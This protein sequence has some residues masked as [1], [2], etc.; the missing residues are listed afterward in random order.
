M[1]EIKFNVHTNMLE[2]DRYT[3]SLQDVAEPEL[4]RDIFPYTE[5]PRITFNHRHVPMNMPEHL[6]ITDTTFRDGQ[7][8]RTPYTAKQIVDIYKLLHKLSGKKGIIRQSEFF[9]YSKKDREA[10]EKCMELG[11]KFP[12]ITT[13]IRASKKD[14]ELVKNLGIKETG[15]LMSCSDYHIF[16]KMGL[17]RGKAMEKYLGIAKDCMTSGL[18]PRCHLEDVTRADIY[19][20]VIPFVIEL[21]KL[22]EES[23]IPVKI[24]VCDTLGLGLAFPGISLPRSIPGIIYGL[25][26]YAGIPSERIEWHGHNDFYKSVA[27]ASTA[28]LY[29]ASNVNC[30]LLGIG[31]RTG[32]VPLEAMVFEYAAFKGTFDG[33]NPRIITEIADYISKETNYTIPPMT[34]FIGENF[35]T[36]KAG[37]HADGLIKDEEIY[38]I[39]DTKLMLNKPPLVTVSNTSGAAGIAYWLNNYYNL[40]ES[41]RFSKSSEL[42]LFIKKWVDNEFDN[43]RVTFISADEM[44]KLV[45][46]FKATHDCAL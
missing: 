36:T 6:Y 34:P 9:V 19:G 21:N 4:Y 15:V 45:A 13:W 3:Y 20:F 24:R 11:Y 30:S 41:K 35:N 5:V 43:G 39:F 29:G 38:N 2:E 31:E 42:V 14:F 25:N 33:M 12:E 8:S 32:N 44:K 28:W 18:V 26:H 37:I 17:T 1:K 10:L 16:N 40:P 7:Q 27:N 46:E 22:S 23:G